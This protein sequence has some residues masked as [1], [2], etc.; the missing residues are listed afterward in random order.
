MYICVQRPHLYCIRTD[1]ISLELYNVHQVYNIVHM[2]TF[3]NFEY[4]I[5]QLLEY[6]YSD[7]EWYYYIFRI[8][9]LRLY[10]NLKEKLKT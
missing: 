9:I 1:D 2:Y 8:R 6:M 7:R 10:K 4:I 5:Q 3:L